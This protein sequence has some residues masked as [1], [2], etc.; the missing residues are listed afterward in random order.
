MSDLL[1]VELKCGVI[2]IEPLDYAVSEEEVI[3]RDGIT[4]P[5]EDVIVDDL[6]EAVIEIK[7]QLSKN[8]WYE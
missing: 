4:E 3:K 5:E 8:A 6:D 7:Y 1:K 2:Y